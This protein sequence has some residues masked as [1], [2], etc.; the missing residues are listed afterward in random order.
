MKDKKLISSLLCFILLLN[1]IIPTY[2]VFT[3][4]EKSD[5]YKR[6]ESLSDE[7]KQYFLQPSPTSLDFKSS[8]KRSTYNLLLATANASD[9][10]YD[11]RS[12][13]TIKVKNQ[14]MSNSC[15]AFTFTSL[16]ENTIAK[17][18]NGISEE[19][20][21]MHIEYKT[22]KLYNRAVGDGG[23][24]KT[25]INYAISGNGPILESM[26]PFDSVYNEQT[27]SSE[28]GY[29]KLPVESVSLDQEPSKRITETVNFAHIN[30]KYENGEM[31]YYKDTG[32]REYTNT[33]IQAIR[34][35]IKNHILEYGAV[36]AHVYNDMTESNGNHYSPS[37]NTSTKSWFYRGNGDKQRNHTVLII[38]WDDDYSVDNFRND[39]KP[40]SNG[41]YIVLNSWGA[42]FGDNGCYYI[43]YEDVRI[44]EELI[45]IKE[46][47]NIEYDNL[48]QYDI[49]GNNAYITY[50]SPDDETASV[51]GANIFDRRE[52]PEEKDEYINEIGLHIHETCGVE[53]Y[54]NPNSDNLTNIKSKLVAVQGGLESGYHTISLPSPIKLTGEKFVVAVKYINN[55]TGA[56]MPL[57]ANFADSG[58]IGDDGWC[59]TAIGNLGESM[60]SPDGEN[61]YDINGP[62]TTYRNTSACIKGF[63]SY[64]DRPAVID[65][66]D[67]RLNKNQVSIEEGTTETLLA[68]V[69]PNNAT[70]QNVRWTSSDEQV[71]TV[72][73]GVITA[74]KAGTT[75][76]TVTTEDG[77]KTATC[78]V[79]VTPRII[80]V[81]SVS[82]NKTQVQMVEGT[83]ETLLATVSPNNATNQNV[84]WTSSD[85]Q[86]ATVN[87]G[88]ITA[89]K[90]GTTIITVT[91]EDGN[92]TATCNVEVI[93]RIINVSNVSL[94]KTQVQMVEGTTETLVATVSPSNATNQ[95]VRWASS[96]EQVA[97]V[98]NGVITAKKA[99]TARITVITEDGNK[100]AVC[101]VEV[102]QKPIEIVNVTNIS[103]NKTQ[104]QMVEGATETLRATISPSNATD[105]NVRWISSNEQVATVSNGVITA[106][107]S[108]TATITVITKDGNKT[109]TCRVEV[110]RKQIEIVNVT[111]IALNKNQVQMLEGT[112]ETLFA[113]ITPSNATNQNVRWNSS[114]EQVATVNNG[115]ITAKKAGTTIIT[116][117]SEDGNKAANCS[118]EVKKGQ[119]KIVNVESVSINKTKIELPQGKTE[120]LITTISPSN[121]TN[122]NVRWISSNEEVASVSG[123]VITAK[124]DGR[125]IITVETVD[126]KKVATCEV[127][128]NKNSVTEIK[129]NKITLNKNKLTMQVEDKIYLVATIEPTNATNQNVIWESS[130]D[131]VL[132]INKN[133]I[134]TALKTGEAVVT[135]KSEDGM[136]EAKCEI[137][138][139]QRADTDDDIYKDKDYNTAKDD[140][141]V[142][143]PI[144]QTGLGTALIVSITIISLG[145]II[146]YVKYRTIKEI[147]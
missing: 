61:W 119:E 20:S 95:N 79:E 124:K 116:V 59:D 70:N 22:T 114:N 40:S 62:Y 42:S 137:K 82:L 120:T 133:G 25:A 71:A 58:L 99:G 8:V 50:R 142:N 101:D 29:L 96:N 28:A 44:E 113:T 118:V 145:A 81:S 126:G 106:K 89:R 77:N 45:G 15:W 23:E 127:V 86:V 130:D 74:I 65:V 64:H 7:E 24:G 131:K 12:E 104:I 3:E 76:I 136:A 16:L 53:I 144:P 107:E 54:I 36:Y 35:Q 32:T 132:S 57:E 21:P 97:T 84:R 91:T 13:M 122:Q 80:N 69:S 5:A 66:T 9:S 141:V 26:L 125:A 115:V 90:V 109:A 93:P 19:Y 103:L 46:V 67:V 134:I 18:N 17:Q 68:T 11:L 63:T 135:V 98:S 14:K 92:K 139:V 108:G 129:V 111:N 140:T 123:G 102:E 33:E 6:W 83:T 51:W 34:N 56:V 1:I 73:G 37:Y 138:I 146:T 27:N 88:V 143:K 2:A 78:N 87:A 4:F 94:N 55:E 105:Q 72:N 39:L 38:G 128:V 121:A 31:K 10:R 41:A 100:T 48:Y 52:L 49:L 30:K 147:K 117:V 85:E 75:I 47:K 112:T 43:S 60:V 110:E